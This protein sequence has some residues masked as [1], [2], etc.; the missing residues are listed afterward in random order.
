MGHN[1]NGGFAEYVKVK[2]E[3]AFHI[4]D[5]LSFN[6]AALGEPVACCLHAVDR[7]EVKYGDTIAVMGA[8]PMGL[9]LA[10]LLTHSNA[11]DVILIASTES[12]LM[13]AEKMGVK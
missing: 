13:R 10:Q 8:G 11:S 9:I 1:I 3:K 6:A 4:P 7:C 12:K 2:K 5:T